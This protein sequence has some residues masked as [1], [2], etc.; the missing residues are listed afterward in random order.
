MARLLFLLL[1]VLAPAAQAAE[2]AAVT[3]PRA[4]ASLISETDAV[5]PGQPY[6]IALRLRMA[7]GWHTYWQNPGDAG[8]PPEV[9]LTLPPGV[10]AGPIAWP[11]PARQ[12]EDTLMT[13]GYSGELVL[14]LTVSGGPGPVTAKA[15]WLVCEKICV[16]EEGSFTLALAAGR[17]APSLEAALF[18]AADARMPRPTPW[19]ARIAP[20]GTLSL[21]GEGIGPDSVAAAWFIPAAPDLI[22]ASRPQP[23]RLAPGR[24][25]LA[26]PTASAFRA[27]A[28]LAG[29][30]VLK[31]RGGA[32]TSL[33]VTATPGPAEVPEPLLEVLG[34]AFLGGLILNLMPCVFPVLAMKAVSL[35]SLS[36]QARGKGRRHAAAYAA[37]VLATF[38]AVAFLLLALRQAGAA[39]GWGFQFQSPI[40]VAGMACVLF[41]VGLNLSGVFV[42]GAT[43]GAGQGLAGRQGVAGSFVA[44]MLAVLVATPCTAPFMSVAITTGLAG[45]AATTIAVFAALGLGLATPYAVLASVPGFARALPRPGRWMVVLRQFLAFPMYAAA[46]W[47][48]WVLSIQAGPPGVLAVLAALTL[49]GFAAWVLGLAQGGTARRLG[50]GAAVLAMLAAVLTLASVTT[51]DAPQAEASAGTEPFSATRLAALRAEG[52]PVFVN[53]TAAWCVTC[54]VN[55]RVALAR[56]AVRDAFADA[57]IAYLKGDWTR[58]DADITEF[59]RSQGADGVPLY[60]F[61]PA[62]KADPRRLP[63]ILT[64]RTV[65]DALRATDAGG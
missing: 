29:V 52:R 44:G 25:S 38:L 14:P 7:P 10:T 42:L 22:A 33:A 37:G 46:V 39:A 57:H 47:L 24:L 35:S 48:V 40:F 32:E 5:L 56:P 49:T 1:F 58:Q 60:L 64:E 9:V 23:L 16:P 4:T 63:Q 31:D 21:A 13:F 28:D 2:S 15:S 6:R 20:D 59:L 54:L 61:Y 41:A 34:L 26:L 45:S 11:V 65:I 18:A 36:G 43:I 3:S 50:Q 17:P 30:L 12:P 19:P 55:E 8:V 27:T 53:M 51:A 62:G